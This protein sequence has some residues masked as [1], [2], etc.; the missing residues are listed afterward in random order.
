MDL[1][2][3]QSQF[4][5]R[6]TFPTRL[7]YHK[8]EREREREGERGRERE[9]KRKRMRITEKRGSENQKICGRRGK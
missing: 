3:R 4:S 7:I 8:Q 6:E 2:M 9:R 5:S 1:R